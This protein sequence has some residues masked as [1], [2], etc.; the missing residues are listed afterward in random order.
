MPDPVQFKVAQSATVEPPKGDLD[1]QKVL[2]LATYTKTVA[3]SALEVTWAGSVE[4][5]NG[6]EVSGCV[7]Q[8]RVDGNPAAAGGGEVFGLNLASVSGVAIFPGLG[9]GAH[10]IEVWAKVNVDTTSNRC[11]VGPAKAGMDQTVVA[12]EIVI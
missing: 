9:I 4:G 1:F 10:T 7:F 2:D 12:H 11:T 3:S 8:L 5:H 6:G